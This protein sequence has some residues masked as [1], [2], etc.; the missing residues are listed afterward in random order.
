MPYYKIIAK[1]YADIRQLE[2]AEKFFL[3]AGAT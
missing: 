3:K 1:H 2:Q